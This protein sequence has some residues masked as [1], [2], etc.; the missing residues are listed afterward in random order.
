MKKK[1]LYFVVALLS[2]NIGLFVINIIKRNQIPKEYLYDYFYSVT[3]KKSQ[4]IAMC[5]LQP[6]N[7]YFYIG[8]DTTN[9][10]N[11]TD[12]IKKKKL[13]FFFSSN[14]CPPCLDNV[15]KLIDKIFPGYKKRDDIIFI[16]NDLELRF[17][18]SYY[19]KPIF[20]NNNKELGALFEKSEMPTFFILDNDLQAKCVFIVDK[21]TPE[22]IEDYLNIMKQRFFLD[23]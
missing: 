20:R 9:I 4:M 12:L 11:I 8:K 10:V 5:E 22:Y 6:I 1:V 15:L 14:T 7:P 16:S 19:G 2:I 17:R 18:E 23:Y 3:R 21:M 13:C